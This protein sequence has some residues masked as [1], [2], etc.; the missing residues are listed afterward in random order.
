MYDLYVNVICTHDLL[1]IQIEN[2]KMHA[3]ILILALCVTAATAFHRHG[4]K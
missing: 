4:R 2:N 1:Q 3:T